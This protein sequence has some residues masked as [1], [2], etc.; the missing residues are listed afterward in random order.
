MQHIIRHLEDDLPS[1]S[2]YWCKKPI[3]A[4]N[5]LETKSNWNQGKVQHKKT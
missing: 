2:L 3:F 4:T 5:H 1:Q